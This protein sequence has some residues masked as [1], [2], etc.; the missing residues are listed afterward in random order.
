MN[1]KADDWVFSAT[2]FLLNTIGAVNPNAISI[3]NDVYN[4][5]T[6]LGPMYS[7]VFTPSYPQSYSR[8]VEITMNLPPG[9]PIAATNVFFANFG[10]IWLQDEKRFLRSLKRHTLEQMTGKKIERYP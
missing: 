3:Y 1:F 7:V 4:P 6:P 5:F 10:R 8:Q 2:P 9:A